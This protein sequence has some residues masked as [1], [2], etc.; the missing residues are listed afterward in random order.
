MFLLLIN[1]NLPRTKIPQDFLSKVTEMMLK[2]IGKPSKYITICVYPDLIMSHAGSSDP[3]A[4]VYVASI[5]KLRLDINKDQ[6]AE[7]ESF[8]H[9]TLNIPV[10]RFL[11]R[12]Q[13]LSSY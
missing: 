4:P 9:E 7:I 6:S 2:E 10:A 11:Y 12:I 1:T 5:G 13:Q 8:I 3:C